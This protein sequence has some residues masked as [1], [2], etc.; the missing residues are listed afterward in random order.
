MKNV[1]EVLINSLFESV[2]EKTREYIYDQIIPEFFESDPDALYEV[3]TEDQVF[4]SAFSRFI[5]DHGG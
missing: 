5:R 3:E 2:N 1:I 4:D